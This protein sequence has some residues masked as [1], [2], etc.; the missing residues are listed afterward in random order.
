MKRPVFTPSLN[1]VLGEVPLNSRGGRLGVYA[2]QV[3][4]FAEQL[5]AFLSFHNKALVVAMTVTQRF[6]GNP[7]DNT[8]FSQWLK[9]VSKRVKRDLNLLRIAYGWFRERSKSTKPHYHLLLVLDGSRYR[10]HFSLARRIDGYRQTVV[11][12]SVGFSTGRMVR[13]GDK[14]SIESVM[15]WVS[16]FCKSRS[17]ESDPGV[18]KC[19]F[20]QLIPKSVN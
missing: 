17:K 4:N 18:R 12:Y 3:S 15:Y 1:T 9:R 14:E 20:S 6:D 11:A 10:S 5:N 7:S 8:L 2:Y 13:R 16:Y 19:G